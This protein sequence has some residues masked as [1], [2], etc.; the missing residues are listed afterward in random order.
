MT[1]FKFTPGCK[2]ARRALGIAIVDMSMTEVG[3]AAKGDA[4][5]RYDL[6]DLFRV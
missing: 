2:R 1:G 6:N 5:S 4:V 3:A